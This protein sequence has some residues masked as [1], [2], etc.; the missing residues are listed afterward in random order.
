MTL[1][2]FYCPY[3][4]QE[5]NEILSE[6]TCDIGMRLIK[7]ISGQVHIA[8]VTVSSLLNRTKQL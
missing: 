4:S 5:V 2:G 7:C 8:S 6:V 3:F 1:Y